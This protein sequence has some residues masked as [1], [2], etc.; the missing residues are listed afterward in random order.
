[1]TIFLRPYSQKVVIA[2]WPFDDLR[3][4]ENEALLMRNL[5]LPIAG[6]AASDKISA[7]R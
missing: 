3:A 2:F 5:T 6:T 4:I 7:I 1:M